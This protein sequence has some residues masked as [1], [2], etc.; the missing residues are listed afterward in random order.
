MSQYERRCAYYEKYS[1]PESQE[2]IF[3]SAHMF[4]I[5]HA[6]AGRSQI[7]A[8]IFRNAFPYVPVGSAGVA[9][10]SHKYTH[11]HP[12]VIQEME[13]HG[14]DISQRTVNHVA[15]AMITPETDVVALCDATQLPDFVIGT[16][17]SVI[18]IS[19]PDPYICKAIQLVG[20][21]PME[22]ALE[23]TYSKLDFIINAHLL[24][25]MRS[26]QEGGFVRSMRNGVIY[27]YGEDWPGYIDRPKRYGNPKPHPPRVSHLY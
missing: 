21:N 2:I 8:G 1:E 17:R 18:G 22:I 15:E 12:L 9:D 25:I 20:K 13:R 3:P 11:P 26:V 5:C 4:F 24:D 10:Y 23:K 16:A 6:N 19:V 27:P 7:A 14:I